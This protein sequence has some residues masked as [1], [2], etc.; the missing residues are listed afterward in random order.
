MI[1]KLTPWEQRNL[2]VSSSVEFIVEQND[3]W[4]ELC[5]NLEKHSEEYQVMHIPGGNTEVL[6][7][8]QDIGFRMIETNLKISRA[9]KDKVEMPRIYQR[10]EPFLSCSIALQDQKKMV[11]DVIRKGEMFTTDKISRDPVFGLA[12][13]GNRYACWSNDVLEQGADL[14]IIKYKEE[15]VAF[16]ICAMYDNNT[17]NAFLGGVL[18]SHAEKGLG[19]AP[20]FMITKYAAQ[21]GFRKIVTGVSS[22][23]LPILKL[24]ELFSYQVEE[25]S[26]CLIRHL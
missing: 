19:F 14:L 2:G 15:P 21:K 10:F 3:T 20:I 24:H 7:H 5:S 18:P 12:A 17:A 23:N 25:L 4:N 11:L 8:A 22:N 13:A 6:L 26:Y 9:L 1:V 16:D